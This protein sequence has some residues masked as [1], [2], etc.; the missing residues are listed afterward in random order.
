ML[1]SFISVF[2]TA[3]R[4]LSCGAIC[5]LTGCVIFI[6][7]LVGLIYN[8]SSVSDALLTAMLGTSL[9]K[10]NYRLITTVCTDSIY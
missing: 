1:R 9:S 3:F 10:K 5:A 8:P 4:I 2:E 6:L 7:G